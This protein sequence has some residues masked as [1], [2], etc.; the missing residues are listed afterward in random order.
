MPAQNAD[1][2]SGSQIFASC[3]KKPPLGEFIIGDRANRASAL[4]S[5]RCVS[6]VTSLALTAFL[7]GAPG[8]AVAQS[9]PVDGSAAARAGAITHAQKMRWL[10]PDISP[11]TQATP[12]VIPQSAAGR[13]VAKCTARIGAVL[14]GPGRAAVPPIR[15]CYL[16]LRR[17]LDLCEKANGLSSAAGHPADHAQ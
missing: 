12:P 2:G 16:P 1:P 15:W 11:K 8:L 6:A 4:Q 10:F 9:I 5:T 17:R 14:C 7:T 13:L 3:K